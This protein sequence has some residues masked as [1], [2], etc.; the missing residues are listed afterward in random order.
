MSTAKITTPHGDV[1]EF[2]YDS[3]QDIMVLMGGSPT[4]QTA[5]KPVVSYKKKRT[6]RGPLITWDKEELREVV[7]VARAHGYQ[8]SAPI[9]SMVAQLSN[10]RNRTELALQ[11]AVHRVWSYMYSPVNQKKLSRNMEQTL[12][13]L[14]VQKGEGIPKQQVTTS[15]Y[16]GLI[17]QA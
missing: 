13:S 17:R 8:S 9:N 16:S 5:N 1:I 7:R 15:T 14:G 12:N 10:P 4:P 3:L 6:S 2:E 11:N